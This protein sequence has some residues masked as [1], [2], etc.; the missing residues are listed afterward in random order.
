[1]LDLWKMDAQVSA[2]NCEICDQDVV[3]E[4]IT[5]QKHGI[6]QAL[7][8]NAISFGRCFT[9]SVYDGCEV[10]HRSYVIHKC[11]KFAFMKSD[12]IEIGPCYTGEKWRGKNIYPFVLMKIIRN[13]RKDG[14]DVYMIIDRE[15]IASQSGVKKVGFRRAAYLKRTKVLRSYHTVK[16]K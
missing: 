3:K 4:R 10:V 1:M 13:E 9:Y 11:Y 15:N 12:D 5:V 6:R 2:V 7:F 16:E 8:W 14:A